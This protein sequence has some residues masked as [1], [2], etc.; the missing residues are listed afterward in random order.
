MSIGISPLDIL[1]LLSL[2]QRTHA[3]WRDAPAKYRA[4]AR[5]LHALQEPLARLAA[6]SPSSPA[7]KTP[8]QP[9][10]A[11][12]HATLATLAQLL[13]KHSPLTLWHRLRLSGAALAELE[14]AL[15]THVRDL[16]LCCAAVGLEVLGRVGRGQEEV[17]RGL[18]ELRGCVER[19]VEEGKGKEE[20]RT[21]REEVVGEPRLLEEP[22][23]RRRERGFLLE[24]GCFRG[25]EDE[26]CARFERSSRSRLRDGSSRRD[27]GFERE[28]RRSFSPR[29]DEWR[30]DED[31]GRWHYPFDGEFVEVRSG[32]RRSRHSRGRERE[33]EVDECW[34]VRSVWRGGSGERR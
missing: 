3:R 31:D 16:G 11:S 23:G 1:T 28:A 9:I 19:L 7:S 30:W 29:R 10:L 6:H 32:R 12:T 15:D 14:A 18:G 5:R 34:E 25:E 27:E 26:R 17:V 33:V 8:L 2:A 13:D 21:G 4:V 22:R 24:G 20:R